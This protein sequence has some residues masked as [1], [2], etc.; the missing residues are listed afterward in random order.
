[1]SIAQERIQE[2]ERQWTLDRQ[3]LA[4]MENSSW[5]H[6][7]DLHC[8]LGGVPDQGPMVRGSWGRTLSKLPR[9]KG[10]AMTDAERRE[11]AGLRS[12]RWRRVTASGQDGPQSSRGLQPLDM[13]QATEEGAGRGHCMRD[14]RPRGISRGS[15]DPRP[16][17][18]RALER[19]S[20]AI[21]AELTALVAFG[22]SGQARFGAARD[23]KCR[24][25]ECAL[26]L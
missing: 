10:P 25:R 17:P 2:N 20:M 14:L 11:K 15:V 21:I 3:S 19:E 12:E 13:V 16:C 9:Y 7:D 18:V 6:M 8:A 4:H 26:W 23:T 5:R 1:M 22:S 24:K